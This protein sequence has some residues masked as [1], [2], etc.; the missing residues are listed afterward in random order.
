MRNF[1]IAI[2][3]LVAAAVGA[4]FYFSTPDIP[5][6]ALE[7]KY[8]SSLSHDVTLPGG[9][10]AHYRERG[11]VNAPALLLLHGSNASLLTWEPWSKALSD[12]FHVVSVDLP[13]HGLTGAVPGDDYSLQGMSRFV[14]AFADKLGLKQFALAGNSMGG[15]VA[16]RFAEEH[17]DRV[18]RL[19][20]VDAG[21]LPFKSGEGTPLA[22]R[23]A[24]IPVLNRILLHVTPRSLVVE[25][26]NKAIVH[27]EIITDAMIDSYWDFARMEGT[28]RATMLRFQ[29]AWDTY[30]R[31][32]TA[33]LKMPVLILWGA[34]DA[35]IPV[36][37][38][39][40]WSKAVPGAKLIVYPKTGHIPMEEVAD[41]SAGDVRA[42]LGA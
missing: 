17:P 14:G 1:L 35:L 10:R 2:L 37:V 33:A 31:D 40:D 39:H 25:G 34:E 42:F 13:G 21:G 23:L 32:H 30:V 11:P 18:T 19:I 20:L 9:A 26:L 12:R 4:F 5:R 36:A 6:A 38:A 27:K 3:V 16:A 41:R 15:A 28:R 8:A 22:F 24:R 29:D 7:A